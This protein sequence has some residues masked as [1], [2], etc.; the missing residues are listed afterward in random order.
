[1]FCPRCGSNQGE[2][3][4]FCTGCGTNLQIVSQA[5]TG[6]LSPPPLANV[7]LPLPPAQEAD[8][9]NEM[10][11]GIT[12]AVLGGGYLLYKIISFIVLAPFS[13]WRSPFGFLGFVAFI[14]FAVGLS[15]YI[16]SRAAI[17]AAKPANLLFAPETFA[18][19]SLPAAH[20][21]PVTSPQPVFSAAT[22]E[23]AAPRTNELEPVRRPAASVTE[24]ETKQLSR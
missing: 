8:W 16:S 10:K 3:K 21:A 6:Q 1:M 14:L 24:E 20:H 9:Q 12:L 2:G 17:A 15:K 22:L 18:Q 13:G 19:T 11:T 7:P 5:L 23:S 4:K